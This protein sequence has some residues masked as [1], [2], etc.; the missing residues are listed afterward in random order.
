M[1][2]CTRALTWPQKQ[3]DPVCQKP[4]F[5]HVAWSIDPDGIEGGFVCTEH[6]A[7]LTAKNWIPA[8]VHEL[9]SECG[10]PNAVWDI[11]QNRCYVEEDG[12]EVERELVHAVSTQEP[13]APPKTGSQ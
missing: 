12:A 9:G 5:L 1:R 3:G 8:Q 6:A 2:I 11:E 7:E 4:P 13:L 10:M